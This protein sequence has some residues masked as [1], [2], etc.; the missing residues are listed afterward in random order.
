MT[1]IP[2]IYEA[3]FVYRGVRIRADVL[4]RAP[5]GRF[6]LV[7]VKSTTSTKPEHEWDVAVQLYVLERAGLRI[8]RAYLAHLNRKYIY[9][10]GRYRLKRLF[11]MED[12]T[13]KAR[14]RRKDVAKPFGRC[15]LRSVWRIHLPL[16]SV[17]TARH[18]TRADSTITATRGSQTTRLPPSRDLPRNF[19]SDW[20]PRESTS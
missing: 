16:P 9:A 1:L 3:A 15:G 6:D 17:L 19:V 5:R 18:P 12:L 20:Q 8:R 10:G 4:V 13:R 7:E 11:A 14:G 2:A